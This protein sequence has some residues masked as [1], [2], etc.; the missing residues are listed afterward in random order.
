MHPYNNI[1]GPINTLTNKL[2]CFMKE[3]LILIA[4]ALA[5]LQGLA[6]DVS[7]ATAQQVAQRFLSNRAA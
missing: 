1:N 2:E 6:A 7:T 4:L 5:T 3:L